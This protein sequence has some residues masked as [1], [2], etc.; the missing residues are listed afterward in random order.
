MKYNFSKDS[1][2]GSTPIIR[3]RGGIDITLRCT[4]NCEMCGAFVPYYDPKPHYSLDYIRKSI[5]AYFDIVDYFEIMTINGGE[6]FLHENIVDIVYY[7]HKYRTRINKLEIITNGTIIPSDDLIKAFLSLDVF[8]LIDDY[9]F[10][11]SKKALELDLLLKKHGVRHEKRL[12]TDSDLYHGGWVDLRLTRKEPSGKD[13]Q[14]ERFLDCVYFKELKFCCALQDGVVYPCPVITRYV[15]LGM[16]KPG[17]NSYL[18]LFDKNKSIIEKKE[19]FNS[20]MESKPFDTCAYCNGY[21]DNSKRY[22]P[23]IQL[24]QEGT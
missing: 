3:H 9:G 11:L 1:I 8:V 6:P 24:V 16:N 10:A 12:Q 18:D 13:E 7:F 22:E 2:S 4:L 17:D 21:S 14:L 23:A 20:L 15:K 5:D 19:W